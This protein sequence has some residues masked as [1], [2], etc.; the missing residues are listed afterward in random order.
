MFHCLVESHRGAEE[1]VDDV[2]VAVKLVVH[3]E[4]EDAHLC[5]AAVVE[6]DSALGSLGLLI[7]G[8]PAE[9][10]SAVTEVSRELARLG[11]V[12]LVLHDE[13]LEEADEGENLEGAGHRHLLVASP[14]AADGS[15]RGARVVD[16][17][18]KADASGGHEVAE[19]S[20]HRDA[21]VLDLYVA[22]AIESLLVSTL[23]HAERVK[24][25]ERR[26]GADLA[27]ESL[28][29]G[30][31]AGSLRRHEGSGGAEGKSDYCGA[32]HLFVLICLVLC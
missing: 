17:T 14:A 5:G 1:V 7:E 25:S 30:G 10:D 8:V 26:L 24:A 16:V 4:G 13:A 22:E 32:E 27:L 23:E 9:V 19:N 20:E 29:H 15:E 6:L 2:R 12:G 28:H 18:R 3:H 11:A 31:G 21:A